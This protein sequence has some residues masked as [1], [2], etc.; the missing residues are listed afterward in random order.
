MQKKSKNI[1]NEYD[2]LIKNGI[3]YI[4][5]N[6]YKEAKIIFKKSI[7]LSPALPNGYLNLSN[8]YLIEKKLNQA[9]ELLFEYISNNGLNI[10]IANHLG[11]IC[12]QYKQYDNLQKLLSM[13]NLKGNKT[14]FDYHILFFFE[15][16]CYEEDLKINNAINSYKNSIKCNKDFEPSYTNLLNLLEKINDFKNLQKFIDLGLY[17]SRIKKKITFIYYKSFLFNR[18]NKF[19]ESEKTIKENNLEHE[20]A[21]NNFFNQRLLDLIAK[22]NEK[23]KNYS[24]S[25]EYIKKRNT[26]LSTLEINKKYDKKI[27]L[28][29][30]DKYKK[31]Y[32]LKNF[33][34][35]PILKKNIKKNLVF[36]VGFP[37][38]GTTLLDSILRSHSLITVLEEKPYLLETRHKFF[39]ENNDNLE[40]L[41]NITEKQINELRNFYFNK[42][43]IKSATEKEVFIDKLPLSIIELGFIK[44]IFPEAKIIL[45][46]R[47]PCDVVIS[48]FFSYFKINE[49]MINFLNLDDTI[50]FYNQTFELLE[51]FERKFNIN[52]YKIKYED[53]IFD[54]KN[55][56]QLL[57][58]YIELSYEEE[59]ENY[60]K[61]AKKRERISTP[62]YS[63][64]I[65]PLYT[66]SIGKWKNYKNIKNPEIDLKKWI[67][68]FDY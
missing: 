56:I 19:S 47:H 37:R 17:S 64:V 57:L 27:I 30:I 40:A 29:T 18:L 58:K 49:A 28:E 32:N 48:C 10:E 38:S 53:I 52:Y 34:N 31:F 1:Q 45:A 3:N 2:S 63:Q 13:F 67:T 54:F 43:N 11:K 6:D 22:N 21:N 60:L 68:K 26:F 7:E 46:L 44:T 8:I 39:K 24:T 50:H 16:R 42:I 35:F 14:N 62:S 36:L 5:N 65:K 4:R 41:L 20:F 66:S 59:L 9:Q 51:S 15:G 33:N 25:F 23:L 55:Q 12:L 61:T